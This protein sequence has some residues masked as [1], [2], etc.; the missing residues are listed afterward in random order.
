LPARATRHGTATAVPC[1]CCWGAAAV[2][3]LPRPRG[4]WLP[5]AAGRPNRPPPLRLSR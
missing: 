1:G 5:P 4:P 3:L 2:L